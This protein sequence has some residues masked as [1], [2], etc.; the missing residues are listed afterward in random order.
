MVEFL[1]ALAFVVFAGFTIHVS[2]KILS[3]LLFKRRW[4]EMKRETRRND[5]A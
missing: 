2:V 5:D 3:S 4:N 1:R